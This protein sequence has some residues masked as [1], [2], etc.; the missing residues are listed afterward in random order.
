[1]RKAIMASLLIGLIALIPLT[2]SAGPCDVSSNWLPLNVHVGPCEETIVTAPRLWR[3]GGY[4]GL[5]HG[6]RGDILGWSAHVRATLVGASPSEVAGWFEALEKEPPTEEN[7]EDAIEAAEELEEFAENLQDF[8]DWIE[9]E[10]TVTSQIMCD[11]MVHK[12]TALSI[13]FSMGALAPVPPGQMIFGATAGFLALHAVYLSFTN[14]HYDPT[15]GQS[16]GLGR[17]SSITLVDW[18]YE[19]GGYIPL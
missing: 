14:C 4:N 8:M 16:I 19:D 6:G 15:G 1:M 9:L 18:S 11:A 2:A 5:T 10:R 17:P 3:G 7:I 13:T 12:A